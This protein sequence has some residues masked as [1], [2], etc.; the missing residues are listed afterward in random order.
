VT[1]P[2]KNKCMTFD[3]GWRVFKIVHVKDLKDGEDKCWGHTDFDKAIISLDSSMD[4]N[5][6]RETLLHEITHTV[7]ETVGYGAD[8]NVTGTNE[9]L[10]VQVSRGFLQAF[11][12]NKELFEWLLNTEEDVL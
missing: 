2:L 7:L 5:T 9:N 11:R 10:T 4:I 12:L 3:S 8:E 1:K 6:Y